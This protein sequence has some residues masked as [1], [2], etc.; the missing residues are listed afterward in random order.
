MSYA[1]IEPRVCSQTDGNAVSMPATGPSWL[2][3][4]C[5]PGQEPV[6]ATGSG[7]ATATSATSAP[8]IKS[9]CRWCPSNTYS[10]GIMPCQKCPSNTMPI[11]DLKYT[12]WNEMPPFLSSS[13]FDLRTGIHTAPSCIHIFLYKLAVWRYFEPFYCETSRGPRQ[14][15]GGQNVEGGRTYI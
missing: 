14:I 6:D 1:W 11:Y 8:G 10:N 9:S 12:V 4:S 3:V 15:F 2:C 13:C 7:S 5:N